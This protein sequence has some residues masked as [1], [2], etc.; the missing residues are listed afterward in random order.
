MKMIC[1]KR[2]YLA[3]IQ[4]RNTLFLLELKFDLRGGAEGAVWR[5]FAIETGQRERFLEYREDVSKCYSGG[6]NHR[7]LKSKQ[8]I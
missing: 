3:S 1:G 6:I 2:V 4:V 7:R 5:K 8:A